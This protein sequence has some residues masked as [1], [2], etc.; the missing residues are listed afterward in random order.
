M[1]MGRVLGVVA[2]ALVFFIAALGL[3]I[4]FTRDEDNIQADNILAENI[5][6]AV[7]QAPD[8]GNAVALPRVARF[9]WD[10]VVIVQPGTSREAISQHLGHEWTGI[11]TVDGGELLLFLD[12]DGKVVRFADYRGSNTFE[13]FE[14]PFAEIDREDATFS[15]RDRV[16]R[17]G[18][19]T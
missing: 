12:R 1:R 8:N 13:G 15:V 16:I 7:T 19:S 6:K 2:G 10:R 9:E 17:P 5:T 14:K 4:Y 3:A 11:D 18:P